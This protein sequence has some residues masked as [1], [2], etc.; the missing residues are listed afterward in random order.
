M[1]LQ[2]GPDSQQFPYSGFVLHGWLFLPIQIGNIFHDHWV[3]KKKLTKNISN[4]KLDK[5]Y[6]DMMHSKLFYG[7]KI[8][9]A[10]GGGFFIFYVP[11]FSKTFFL[12]AMAKKKLSQ[13]IFSFDNNGMRSWSNRN[14]KN[15]VK[16]GSIN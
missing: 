14:I 6:N 3:E 11:T 2:L 13:T 12:R 7:G 5:M 1:R 4:K 8:M 16:S 9:G 15:K 10:G